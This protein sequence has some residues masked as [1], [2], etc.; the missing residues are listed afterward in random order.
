M[1]GYEWIFSKDTNEEKISV[2]GG[3]NNHVG[4]GSSVLR[5]KWRVEI[6]IKKRVKDAI[7]IT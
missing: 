6:C 1:G 5:G 4:K 7:L 2:G 3:L